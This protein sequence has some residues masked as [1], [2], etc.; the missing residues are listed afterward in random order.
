MWFNSLSHAVETHSHQRLIDAAH[1][2]F[3]CVHTMDRDPRLDQID[4]REIQ[5]RI[6]RSYGLYAE[7]PIVKGKREIRILC[8]APGVDN[9]PLQGRLMVESLDY[10]DLHYT[11]LSYTWGGSVGAGNVV[12]FDGVPLNITENLQ[13]ALRHFRDPVRW[14]NIWIDAICINQS[15]NSEKAY[16]VALMGDI[17]RNATRTWVW[18]GEGDS[19]S[20]IAMEVVRSIQRQPKK[21]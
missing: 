16:Q 9:A 6:W 18:L 3:Q 20:D 1:R 21:V 13:S 5:V 4:H 7:A 17:Y 12:Y 10:N 14:K 15:D 2:L 19:D 8:L 11:A